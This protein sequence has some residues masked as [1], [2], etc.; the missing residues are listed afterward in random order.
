[1]PAGEDIEITVGMV[2]TSVMEFEID[3][4][5]AISISVTTVRTLPVFTGH[6]MTPAT[7]TITPVSMFVTVTICITSPG[8]SISIEQVTGTLITT[9]H[10]GQD[11]PSG[12]VLLF[13]SRVMNACEVFNSLL[14]DTG[15]T[16]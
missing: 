8:T 4:I 3:T 10:C 9:R 16:R 1:M 5:V 13:W 15:L 6:G 7:T 2:L 12:R 11:A 14:P